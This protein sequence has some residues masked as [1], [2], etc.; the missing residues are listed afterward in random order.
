[1]DRTEAANNLIDV[2]R[3]AQAYQKAEA[4]LKFYDVVCLDAIKLAVKPTFLYTQIKMLLR[5]P[6]LTGQPYVPSL[7]QYWSGNGGSP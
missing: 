2:A 5:N 1:M 4:Q 7:M 3:H 6:R